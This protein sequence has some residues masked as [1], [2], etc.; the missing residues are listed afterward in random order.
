MLNIMLNFDTVTETSHWKD[1]L[2]RQHSFE[3]LYKKEE[4]KHLLGKNAI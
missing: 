3:R 4:S 2:F 1:T